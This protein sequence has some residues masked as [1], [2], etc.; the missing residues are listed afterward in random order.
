MRGC[1][2]AVLRLNTAMYPQEI[3]FCDDNT[4]ARVAN[5]VERADV[6]F[7][8]LAY[9]EQQAFEELRRTWCRQHPTF[10]TND[11]RQPPDD[12]GIR[13]T[14]SYSVTQF[15]IPHTDLPPV[16]QQLNQRLPRLRFH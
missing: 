4:V 6:A 2:V 3:A 16:L 15:K 14:Q 10:Q 7:V 13:C 12:M 9:E 8:P 1:I 11:A 5:P